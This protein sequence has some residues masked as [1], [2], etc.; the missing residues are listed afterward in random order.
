MAL[1]LTRSRTWES[2]RTMRR[3]VKKLRATLWNGLAAQWTRMRITIRDLGVMMT[4]LEGE[5]LPRLI[6]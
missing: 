1:G 4:E 3:G 5:T 6:Q 2:T